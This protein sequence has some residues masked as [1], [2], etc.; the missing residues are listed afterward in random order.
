MA[1]RLGRGGALPVGRVQPSGRLPGHGFAQLR[2]PAGSISTT[3]F[4]RALLAVE[5]GEEGPTNRLMKEVEGLAGPMR[6]LSVRDEAQSP[7][8]FSLTPTPCLSASA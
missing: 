7:A 2:V 4:V 6:R 1:A 3:A 8:G 5:L